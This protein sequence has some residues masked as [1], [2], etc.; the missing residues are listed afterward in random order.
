[1]FCFIT[2]IRMSPGPL[3]IHRG[4]INS[5]LHYTVSREILL[6]ETGSATKHLQKRIGSVCLLMNQEGDLIH[7]A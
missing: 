2:G 3:K 7:K 1:M 5:H 6:K 4:M